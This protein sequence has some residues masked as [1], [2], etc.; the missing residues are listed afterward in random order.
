MIQEFTINLNQQKYQVTVE[1]GAFERLGEW[2]KTLHPGKR[3]AVITDESVYELYGADLED[4]LKQ[5]EKKYLIIKVPAGED[6]KDFSKLPEIYSRLLNFHITRSDSLLSFGGGVVGDITGFVAA[7]YLRGIDYFQLPTTVISQVDSSIGG[8]VAVNLPEAHNVVGCF[9]QPQRVLIDPTFVETLSD[10]EFTNGLAEIIKVAAVKDELLF[11]DL[12]SQIRNKE[13]ANIDSIIYRSGLA[14]KL[15]IEEDEKA[16]GVRRL[17]NFGH[18]LGHA[19][20]FLDKKHIY[21]H[22]HAV[23]IGMYTFTKRSEEMG[24]TSPG[25]TDLLREL[26]VGFDIPYEMPDYISKDDLITAMQS[27]KKRSGDTL[28]LAL[29][30]K[31]GQGFIHPVNINDL[32]DFL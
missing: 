30:K 20:R 1:N 27:D 24:L 19:I 2:L 32:G 3:V 18:T 31:I 7:T 29:L 5:S 6:S 10:F 25:T 22:G 9:Y 8:K 15:V 12:L 13:D 17:L 4:R 26:F 14:K 16:F 11:S 28:N 23:A 21:G